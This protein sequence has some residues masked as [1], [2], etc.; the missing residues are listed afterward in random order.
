MLHQ[1]VMEGFF[2]AMALKWRHEEK[3]EPAMLIA[4][5]RT[6]P[7]EGKARTRA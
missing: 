6:F 7:A 1:V 3:K 4:G 5:N 2:E